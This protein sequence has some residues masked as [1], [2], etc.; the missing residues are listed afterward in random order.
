[1]SYVPS[2]VLGYVHEGFFESL[3]V[4]FLMYFKDEEIGALPWWSTG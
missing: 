2:I 3:E 4:L 1:M